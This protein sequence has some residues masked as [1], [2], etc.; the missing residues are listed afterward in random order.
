MF[1]ILAPLLLLRCILRR[2]KLKKLQGHKA[3]PV[4]SHIFNLLLLFILHSFIFYVNDIENNIKSR[5]LDLRRGHNKGCLNCFV[6][7]KQGFLKKRKLFQGVG[8]VPSYPDIFLA[9]CLGGGA[10]LIVGKYCIFIDTLQVCLIGKTDRAQFYDNSHNP[11]RKICPDKL[12]KYV[13]FENAP[14]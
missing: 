13:I 3:V 4:L 8:R 14:I 10:Q 12:S 2:A 6:F 5:F 7:F 1:S 9:G 11:P